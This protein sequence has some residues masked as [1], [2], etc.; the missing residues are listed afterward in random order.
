MNNGRKVI[1][2]NL[3]KHLSEKKNAC[4]YYRQIKTVKHIMALK[5]IT[6]QNP[7]HALKNLTIGQKLFLEE[8]EVKI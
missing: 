4:Q 5:V 1:Y 2:K 7:E 6:K 8:N 3:I